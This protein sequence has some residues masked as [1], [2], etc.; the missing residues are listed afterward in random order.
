MN[1]SIDVLCLKHTL[2]HVKIPSLLLAISRTGELLLQC[3]CVA[4]FERWI[5]GHDCSPAGFAFLPSLACN[6]KPSFHNQQELISLCIAELAP[7]FAAF[8]CTAITAFPCASMMSPPEGGTAACGM[9]WMV[10]MGQLGKR[11]G[12][13]A[14]KKE[15]SLN[16]VQ[17]NFLIAIK[18]S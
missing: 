13:F 16:K 1:L 4:R 2:Q 17:R 7:T 9:A 8:V 12:T 14:G 18:L 15:F 10:W 6:G 11:K 3:N 5:V